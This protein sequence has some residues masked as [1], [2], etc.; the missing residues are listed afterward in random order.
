MA[1][2][3]TTA[4]AAGNGT[5]KRPVGIGVIGCGGRISGLIRQLPG[6]GDDVAVTALCDPNPDSI[7]GAR[8]HYAAEA[9]QY[10]DYH[11]L[12]Q[13]PNVDWVLIGSWNCQHREHT[14][15]AFE[16]GKHVFCEKPLATTLEDCVAMQ[17]AHARAGT[18]FSIG[19]TLRYSPHYRKVREIL[20]AGEIGEIVSFEFNETLDFNHGGFIHGDWRR[21]TEWAGTHLLEKC[22]HDIDLANWMVGSLARRVASFGGCD[23]FTPQNVH[24]Q[25]RIG[26]HPEN[27][28]PAFQTWWKRPESDNPFTADKDI[29]DNQ[30]AIIEYANRVR[31]TFHTNCVAGI[32]E[33]RMYICGTEGAIRADV[34][35]GAIEVR[36]YGWDTEIEPRS[37]D[38]SGGHGG[39]DQVLT[40]SLVESMLRG[41]EPFTSLEDGLK[42]AVTCFAIDDAMERREVVDVTPY[43]QR[44]GIA[45]EG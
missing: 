26:P 19:F 37:T 45:C 6:L 24:H 3:T 9:K 12:V 30:V 18:Q 40:E 20:E 22:C 43:W 8:E 2:D 38:A 31:A 15:A 13:D 41:A 42:S 32:P 33:R 25:E 1:A 29:I 21:K 23:F 39:G 11:A 14:V 34:I 5:A 4:D 44:C 16:A 17:E 35:A 10:D 7:R 27:G 28:H 36:R